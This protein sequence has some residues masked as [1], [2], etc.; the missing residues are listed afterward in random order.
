MCNK[1]E[2][3]EEIKPFSGTVACAS[4]K[5]VLKVE[6]IG[7]VPGTLNGRKIILTNVLYVPELNGHLI[8]VKNIQKTGYSVIFK[9]NV[10]VIEKSSEKFEFA[11]LN[12][13]GQ[14]ASQFEPIKAS[15]YFVNHSAELWH[16][17]T[18]LTKY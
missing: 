17:R 3:F 5:D 4:K 9:N 8:S 6:G 13:K 15:T 2:W 1:G 18:H 7:T 11:R 14:Y 16:R 10:A 12:K